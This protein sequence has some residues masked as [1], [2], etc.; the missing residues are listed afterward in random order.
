MLRQISHD[1]LLLFMCILSQ[2]FIKSMSLLPA[3]NIDFTSVTKK[4]KETK[5]TFSF[6]SIHPDLKGSKK[7][8]Q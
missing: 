5:K 1:L 7:Q 8:K 4:G 2:Q 6:S 3:V